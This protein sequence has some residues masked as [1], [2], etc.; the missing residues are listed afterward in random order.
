MKG[1]MKRVG[2]KVYH[3]ASEETTFGAKNRLFRGGVIDA[4]ISRFG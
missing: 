1:G 3:E 2:R 4:A